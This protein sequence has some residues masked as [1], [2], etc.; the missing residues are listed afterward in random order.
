MLFAGAY[1]TVSILRPLIARDILGGRDFGAKSG[2]LALPYLIGSA[3]APWL[4]AMVWGIGGYGLMFSLLIGLIAL[5]AL[6]YLAAHT[7]A[8]RDRRKANA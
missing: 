3:S 2:A 4:G 1:G 8:G 6:L 7:R 5:G